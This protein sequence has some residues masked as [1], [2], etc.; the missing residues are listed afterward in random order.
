MAHY[1]PPQTP[2]S[3]GIIY[4][5]ASRVTTT[6]VSIFPQI[7]PASK[8]QGKQNQ[9]V[10]RKSVDFADLDAVKISSQMAIVDEM[11]ERTKNLQFTGL[12]V[13]LTMTVAMEAGA[14][15]SNTKEKCEKTKQKIAKIHS[16]MRQGYSAS[17]GIRM[18]EELRRLRKLRSKY[19]R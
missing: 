19:C 17:Q 16:K 8:P 3:D 12:L 2:L 10:C 5:A 15:K 14:A 1:P 7:A 13:L 11:K 4:L 6:C 9:R 18:D